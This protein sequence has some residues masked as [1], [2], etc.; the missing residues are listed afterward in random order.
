MDDDND[1]LFG[2]DTMLYEKVIFEVGDGGHA[3][4]TAP[5]RECPIGD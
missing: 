1:E 2:R 3:E 4:A 5:A